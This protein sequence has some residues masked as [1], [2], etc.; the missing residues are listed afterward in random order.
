MDLSSLFSQDQMAI[1]GCF[2]AMGVC[3]LIATLSFKLGP[4]G[5]QTRTQQPTIPMKSA[6]SANS[7]T[8]QDRRAA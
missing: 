4:V 2:A 5:Q 1:L 8:T 6:H 7:S 3:G